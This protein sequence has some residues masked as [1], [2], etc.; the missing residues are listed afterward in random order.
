MGK[1]SLDIDLVLK[2][3]LVENFCN[4]LETMLKDNIVVM[5]P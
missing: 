2:K 5:T 4:H 1:Q 3:E